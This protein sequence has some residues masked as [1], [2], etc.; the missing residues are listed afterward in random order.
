MQSFRRVLIVAAALSVAAAI[1]FMASAAPNPPATGYP[2]N[3]DIGAVITN[4]ARAVGTIQGSPTTVNTK[5][6]GVT[7]ATRFVTET[8]SP[9][10][11]LTIQGYDAASNSWYSIKAS[12]TYTTDDAPG[13]VKTLTVYPGV[14]VSSLA[15]DNEAQS[16]VLPRVWRLNQVIGGSGTLTST[17]GCNYID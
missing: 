6:R 5:W 8:G 16:A 11:V 4:T 7:C 9:T 17:V 14:A 2:V 10:Q 15:S 3:Q 12:A 1:P 13:T